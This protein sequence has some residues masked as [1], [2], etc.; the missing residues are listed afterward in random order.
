MEK[1]GKETAGERRRAGKSDVSDREIWLPDRNGDQQ[2]INKIGGASQTRQEQ[3]LASEEVIYEQVSTN[4][5]PA[6]LRQFHYI[7]IKM[8]CM[9]L[10]RFNALASTLASTEKC[11]ALV[12]IYSSNDKN[13][14][15][16]GFTLRQTNI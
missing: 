6:I 11:A 13:S 16:Y 8:L 9:L 10:S 12:C 3:E 15:G 1:L 7:S 14:G 2:D 4:K 5:Y